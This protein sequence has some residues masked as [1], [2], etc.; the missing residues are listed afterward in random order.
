MSSD[1]G[2][3][4]GSAAHLLEEYDAFAI[5][6]DGVV[7]RGEVLIP[8]AIDGLK[9]IRASGKPMLLLTN[10][11][12]YH[13]NEVVERLAEGGFELA[14]EEVLTT[15]L[16]AR[17]WILQNGMKGAPA[18]IL[19]PQTVAAQLADLLK[20]R[21]LEA[22]QTAEFV[23]CGRDTDFSYIRLALA[24]DA[25]RAGASFLSLNKDPVMPIENGGMLP[26]TGSIVA[27]VEAA[28]GKQATVLGKPEE[29]MMKAAAERIGYSKV[30]ML[31]DRLESDIVG[32]KR[33]GWDGALV[34]TG[35]T[36]TDGVLDPRPDHILTSLQTLAL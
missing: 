1:N 11:G 3:E 5:D 26:G 9:A 22:G 15:S 2:V 4:L 30:L 13:P 36:V 23:L 35:L 19:A 10:N 8:G 12:G 6:L 14:P 18:F 16:V 24:A 31:G 20:I 29:P 32:A 17:E 21:Y 25:V 34:L 28:S 7:W 33:I 27:A